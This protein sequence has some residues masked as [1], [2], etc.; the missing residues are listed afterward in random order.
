MGITAEGETIMNT[1]ISAENTWMLMAVMFGSVALTIF[2]EQKYVWGSRI[3]GAVIV[4]I[5][6]VCLTNF[7]IIPTSAPIFDDVVWGFAVPMAIPLL[8]LQSDLKKIMH[9]TG[10]MLAIF[11]IGAAGT[12]AGVI[13]GY[14]LLK[15]AISGLAGVA[16]MMAGSYIGGGVN[17]TALSATFEVDDTLISAATVAD[18]LNMAIYFMVLLGVAGNAWF[19]RH[20]PH[21][22]I[23]EFEAG[24]KDDGKTQAE[25]YWSRKDISLKD[26]AYCM[27]YSVIVV[28]IAKLIA[29]GLSSLIPTGNWFLNMLSTFFGSQYVWITTIAML[30]ATF[31]PKQAESMHGAQ[32]LGTWLIYLFYFA[33]G[34]PASIP[35]ILRNAPLLVFCLIVVAVNMLFCFVGGK[36]LHYS[37][38]DVIIASNANIGGPTTAAGMAIS[39]GWYKLVGPAMLVGTLGYVIGTYLGIIVGSLLGA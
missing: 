6:A 28:T 5:I 12:V 15:N 11:L 7:R 30:F 23:D 16:A 25:Q 17:F 39:Q 19:R 1:L 18:N 32:E 27:A 13:L 14:E 20:Y 35:L 38:E 36:M 9:E 22:H 24:R 8:L 29:S 3:S 33:I 2:L 26:I 4:L 31:C 34:V 37:L 10:P 21:P